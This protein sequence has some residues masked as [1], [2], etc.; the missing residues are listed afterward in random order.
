MGVAHRKKKRPASSGSTRPR[1]QPDAARAE[2]SPS[3]GRRTSL[4]IGG[5]LVLAVLAVFGCTLGHDFVNVDDGEYVLD[6]PWVRNGLDWR[7]IAWA[8][9]HS[10]SANWHPLTWISHMLD[11]QWF[12]LAAAGHHLT[13]VLLHGAVAVVLFLCLR[14]MTGAPWRSAF[15]AALFAVH[16]LRAES[17]AWVAERKDVLSGLF[18]VLTLWA[19]AGYAQRRSSIGRYLA[20]LALF[21][22]G[23][24]AKQMLVT[25]PF[26]LLLLDYWPLGRLDRPE[27]G[28]KALVLEKIPA[29][30]LALIAS[31]VTLR[32]QKDA[33]VHLDAMPLGQRVINALLSYVSYLGDFFWP[34]RLAAYYP[35]PRQAPPSWQIAAAVVLLAAIT[36]AAWKVRARRPYLLVGWLWYVGMLVPVIGIV[37]V[38][39]QRMADRYTYLPEIGLAV[40]STWLIADL[41][42]GR[43]HARLLSSAGAALVLAL[44][45]PAAIHATRAWKD[46]E[47]LWGRALANTTGN[48]FAHNNLGTSLARRGRLAE[49]VPHFEDALRLE[50]GNFLAHNN[51]G[52]A[53]M[54]Q[55]RLAEAVVHYQ[56]AIA[57]ESDY[58]D[59]EANLGSALAGRG[60]FHEAL[61]HFERAVRLG[62]DGEDVHVKLGLVLTQLGRNAEAA[63][64]FRKALAINPRNARVQG[65]LAAASA[66]AKAAAR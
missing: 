45:L 13:S 27:P 18:F 7:G 9:T 23:L 53:L 40:A 56:K 46:S 24:M 55:D 33:T 20:V 49:A 30:A 43:K 62:V 25:L 26:V 54:V 47:T 58:G 4:A 59:A 51:L 5:F 17:V 48:A 61:S 60:Q 63:E 11:C 2:G 50:P 66:A 65:H 16:P 42:A 44:L 35:Y 6:N 31:W 8:F 28:R 52:V 21:A 37:Q 1:E 3:S 10:A 29:L 38:G 34:S 14:Q 41:A 57:L 19:Y 15:A 32:A 22:C 64:Q 39:N 12:G 36:I